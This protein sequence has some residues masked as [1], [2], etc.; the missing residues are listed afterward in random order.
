MKQEQV[1][2]TEESE[3]FSKDYSK[4][5]FSDKEDYI[6]KSKKGL[7][8]EVVEEIS[9]MKN[10]PKWMLDFRL[11]SLEIFWKKAMPGWG[12]D[13]STIDFDNIYYYIKPSEKT[14]KN[15]EDVPEYIKKTFD[16]LGIP[17]AERKFLSGVGAQYDSEMVYHKIRED[18]EK[19]GVIFL[20][21][22][23]R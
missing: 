13:L 12:A 17:E 1:L 21:M 7:T 14:E 3:T 18:L 5:A 19:Q 15:W 10:E 4:Y 20:D 16:K 2:K 11:Q 8:K 23:Y 22:D 9:K 6:F